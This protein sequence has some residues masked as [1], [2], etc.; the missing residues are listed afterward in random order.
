MYKCI[1]VYVDIY[2]YMHTYV[3][4]TFT[5]RGK[6]ACTCLYTIC[7]EG[8]HTRT[9]ND[10]KS[11]Y[12]LECIYTYIQTHRNTDT[13]AHIHAQQENT[14]THTYT[15]VKKIKIDIYLLYTICTESVHAL[16]HCGSFFDY[17]Q[18]Y[19]TVQITVKQ[20]GSM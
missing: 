14:Q 13:R 12:I 17:I 6:Q 8:M 4:V 15:Y 2:I 10:T 18:A 5:P 7:A 1:H 9:R 11:R 16:S 20:Q 3:Y 19:R